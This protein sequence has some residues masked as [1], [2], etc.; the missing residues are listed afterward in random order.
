MDE[1]ATMLSIFLAPVKM[2]N[3]GQKKSGSREPENVNQGASTTVIFAT[4]LPDPEN[5][6]LE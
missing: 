4:G 3:F 5:L 1:I 2:K 6:L